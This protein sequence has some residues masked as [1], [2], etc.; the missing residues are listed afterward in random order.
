MTSPLSKFG[1]RRFLLTLGCGIITSALVWF[2]KISDSVYATVIVATV[3][4]YIT[5]GTAQKFSK[6]EEVQ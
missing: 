2:G 3:A 6:H 4:A 1:G 5:G